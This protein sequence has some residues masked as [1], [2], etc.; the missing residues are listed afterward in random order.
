MLLVYEVVEVSKLVNHARVA[1]PDEK[2]VLAEVIDR[3][4]LAQSFSVVALANCKILGI[5]R[6]IE[7]ARIIVVNG[8]HMHL[9]KVDQNGEVNVQAMRHLVLKILSP[10]A[11]PD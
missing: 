3:H 6:I 10:D 2:E 8:K 5:G 11:G 7:F 1:A 4:R 9:R